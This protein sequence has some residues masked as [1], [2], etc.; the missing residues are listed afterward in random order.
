MKLVSIM[1]ENFICRSLLASERCVMSWEER[2]QALTWP[3]AFLCCHV[4]P[5]GHLRLMPQHCLQSVSTSTSLSDSLYF[6]FSNNC[7]QVVSI[8]DRLHHFEKNTF[9]VTQKN[10]FES[11]ALTCRLT[12]VS[13]KVSRLSLDANIHLSATE[14][15]IHFLNK[16][17]HSSSGA[18]H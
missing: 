3:Y 12:S 1:D 17:A 9:A 5:R 15:V 8:I 14:C 7:W 4:S 13:F 11:S 6:F 16:S 18:V 2:K 10:R